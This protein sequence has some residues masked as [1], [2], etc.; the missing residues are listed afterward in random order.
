MLLWCCGGGCRIVAV[1]QSTKGGGTII[2]FELALVRIHKDLGE[3]E[4]GIVQI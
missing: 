1:V 2:S 4:F 3:G